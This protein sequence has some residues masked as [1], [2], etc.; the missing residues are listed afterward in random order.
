M[1]EWQ[2]PMEPS[3]VVMRSGGSPPPTLCTFFDNSKTS[4]KDELSFDPPAKRRRL[5]LNSH[6]S[7]RE[8]FDSE[9]GDFV[10]LS[11]CSVD[12]VY[13]RN[14]T[15]SRWFQGWEHQKQRLVILRSVSR[16]GPTQAHL[17]IT[18]YDGDH[19][20]DGEFTAESLDTAFDTLVKV[21]RTR[22]TAAKANRTLQ[23]TPP[24]VSRC[25]LVPESS[26]YSFRLMTTLSWRLANTFEDVSPRVEGLWR[27]IL[28][29]AFPGS[30]EALQR[31]GSPQDF[32]S[33]LHVPRKDEDDSTCI[34]DDLLKSTLFPF[35]KRA[36]KWL[37]R[38]ENVAINPDGHLIRD[39]NVR[40]D[41][42]VPSFHEVWDLDGRKCYV[43]H[44][45][46]IITADVSKFDVAHSLPGG[47]LAEEMGLGK[48]VELI[49]LIC[50]NKR[51]ELILQ[52]ASPNAELRP[53]SSTLI[54]TP[55]SILQQWKNELAMHAPWLNVLHYEGMHS[56][57]KDE[58]YDKLLEDIVS[59]DVVLTTYPVLAREIH[60]A[61]AGPDRKLRRTKKYQ[62]RRS[63]L[64]QT[65]WWRVCLDEAQMVEGGVSN[66]AKVARL[67][68]RCNG[69]AVSGTPLRSDVTD[70]YGLLNFLHYEP[71]CY[72]SGL[73]KYLLQTSKKSFQMMFSQITLRHSKDQVRE[74]LRL[75][76]QKRVVVTVP[77]TQ[78]EEQHYGNLYQQM[79]DDCGLDK[80]GAPT[81]GQ[82][83]P[84]DAVV[85]ERMR[86]WLTRLRQTCLHPEVGGRNR[87]ALRLGGGPLRTVSEVLE[88]MIEQ[89]ETLVRSEERTYLV[90]RIQ[91]GQV[92]ENAL[93]SREALSIWLDTLAESECLVQECRT[94]LEQEVVQ[95]RA[96]EK[97]ADQTRLARGDDSEKDKLSDD[98]E[99]D[100]K[101]P[102]GSSAEERTE[103]EN[104]LGA[105]RQR[106]RAAL[107]LEHMCVF[108]AASGNFQIK[109]NTEETL[110][111]SDDF[112]K[113]EKAETELYE[114]ARL[115]R[116]E[117]LSE[118]RG[119]V[120]RLMQK[121]G[122]K[123]S[124]QAFVQIPEVIYA[125]H[126]GGIE[127]RK[128]IEKADT[129]TEAL[130]N[131]ANQLDEWR[132]VTIKFLRQRLVDEEESTDIQGDEYE[133]STAQQNEV[134]VYMEALAALIA[135]RRDALTGQK[136]ALTAHDVNRALEQAEKGEHQ[137]SELTKKLLGIRARLK[138][139][140][141][142]G[143]VRSIISEL[144]AMQTGLQT[145]VDRS[146]ARMEL[147]IVELELQRIQRT[148][149]EQVKVVQRLERE[150]DL[151]RTTSNARL[152]YYRQLQQISDTVAPYDEPER[153]DRDLCLERLRKAEAEARKKV[154]SLKSKARY[155]LHLRQESNNKDAQR[156][157]IICQQSFEVGALTVCG[158][159]YCKECM[160]LWWGQHRSCPVCK[161]HL[162]ANDFHQITYKPKELVLQEEGASPPQESND[163]SP[164]ALIYSGI[165]DSTLN[166][167]KNIDLSG[168][169]GTKIDTLARHMLWIRN[170][171]PSA[172]S[173]IFSQYRDFLKVVER[174]LSRFGIRFASIEQ[175]GGI[176]TFKTDSAVECFLLH[177]K[178]HS[179]GLNLVNA[180]HVVLC[181]P[182]INTALELQ[183]IARVQRIGQHRPTTVWMYLVSDTVEESIYEIS[184]ARRLSH[185]GASLSKRGSDGSREQMEYS[186]DAA[187]SLELQQAALGKLLTKDQGDGEVVAKDDLWN[188]LFR[189]VK[190][191]ANGPADGE[192]EVGRLLRASAAEA[193]A[194]G[195][196]APTD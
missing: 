142:D 188:C 121:V 179:S 94:V 47:I 61:E 112:H 100:E 11:R 160:R 110:P 146:S 12:F 103:V 117:M 97:T 182:L 135:D 8:G 48:T 28:A 36:V 89:N 88:V 64:V 72:N 131:Q 1:E 57:M 161:K 67:I 52:G 22:P 177:A 46:G 43:S 139:D 95:S 196:D 155:L 42:S 149:N 171:D 165:S 99:D 87:R 82:W 101:A 73:W 181:E 167:I 24:P 145:H 168:S 130:N 65:Q 127:S 153:F 191:T 26:G 3:T 128:L 93:K 27:T 192:S 15:K 156:M 105:M 111:D 71:Y 164:R 53:S 50:L 9:T 148:S 166:Q 83:D 14:D 60:F 86:R 172:Q 33:S 55:S 23:N 56:K 180:T 163:D 183:A 75:P 35:Q 18:T 133:A 120:E 136:N 10:T 154:A 151:F 109:S 170:N 175:K 186:I 40:T 114:R 119:R 68:P 38:R 96:K 137:V 106:L 152:Q 98:E 184:V 193:R 190:S 92:L 104:R 44:V 144:K 58:A 70:L 113:L 159:Q 45:L 16:I 5:D 59:T 118:V 21:S 13:T 76:P 39:A 19:L 49:A 91:R 32:Y 140:E 107:E 30:G 62:S 6:A 90:S 4:R 74:E 41:I 2:S 20:L 17:L 84:D 102:R 69:W 124:T 132:E 54:I 80:D 134:Y 129:L 79:C 187:N 29:T 31:A 115:I 126:P 185:V 122:K 125:Q 173:I 108:F 7:P 157:C 194:V 116:K 176:E 162:T 78:I 66:S 150:L 174:A 77:F 85:I 178:A 189:R 81:D 141:K 143:S 123:A 138:P 169:F 25:W 34:R 37:L 147:Q 51:P 195:E 158:H 63:P